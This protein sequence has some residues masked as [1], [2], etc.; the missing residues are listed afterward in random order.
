M[1]QPVQFTMSFPGNQQFC[2]GN[3]SWNQT[4]AYDLPSMSPTSHASLPEA[5]R[6]RGLYTDEHACGILVREQD[7]AL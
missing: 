3:L 5:R 2:K 4:Y 7:A 6:S 1:P